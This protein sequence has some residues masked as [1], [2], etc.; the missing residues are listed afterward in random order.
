MIFRV[1]DV[2]YDTVGMATYQTGCPRMPLVYVAEDCRAVFVVTL[3]RWAGC[4]VHRADSAESRAL[5][6]RFDLPDV[7]RVAG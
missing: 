6:H 5:A 1:D 2:E 4:R 3:D 7:A